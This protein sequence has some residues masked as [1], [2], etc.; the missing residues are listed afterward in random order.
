MVKAGRQGRYALDAVDEDDLAR[1][2]E[3]CTSQLRHGDEGARDPRPASGVAAHESEPWATDISAITLFVEDLD[4]AE[5]FYREALEQ[6]V[7]FRDD[8]SVVFRFGGTLVNLLRSSA[9]DNLIKPARRFPASGSRM[10]LTVEL[11]D[12]DAVCTRLAASGVHLLNGPLDRP[13]SLRTASFVDPGRH[14][15]EIAA[16][17]R[18]AEKDD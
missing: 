4:A 3:Q 18:G 11:G 12:V 15:W 6:P 17:N 16:P 1:L 9:A 13:W 7:V 5:H 10:V 8:N 2:D 14:I